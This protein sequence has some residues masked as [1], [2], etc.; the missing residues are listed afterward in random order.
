MSR[1]RQALGAA[2]EELAASWYR[3]RGFEVVAR[4][5]RCPA[6]ELDLIVRR[7]GLVVFVEVKTRTT[8]AYGHPLETVTARQRE[9]VRRAAAA[10]IAESGHHPR[11]VRVDVA[12]V[13]GGVVD[14][15]PDAF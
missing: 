3:D 11:R 1:A 10:W 2:G 12:A 9:R 14:V 4:N 7:S 6:G 13:M 5:W 15:V 8:A